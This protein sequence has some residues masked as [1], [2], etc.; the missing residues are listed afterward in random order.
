MEYFIWDTYYTGTVQGTWAKGC[1][2]SSMYIYRVLEPSSKCNKMLITTIRMVLLSVQILCTIS[3]LL[4][5]ISLV[6]ILNIYYN[7]PIGDHKYFHKH[8]TN[9]ISTTCIQDL[10]FNQ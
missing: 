2:G 10:R 4:C 5:L 9:L 8:I 7:M 6:I 1:T 3:V